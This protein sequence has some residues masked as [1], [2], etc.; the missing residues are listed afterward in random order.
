MSEFERKCVVVTGASSGIGWHAARLFALAGARVLAHYNRN[1]E[2]AESLAAEGNVAAVQADLPESAGI[3]PLRSAVASHLGGRVDVLVNNAGSLVQ[4][5]RFLELDEALWDTVFALNLKSA[6]LCS[7]AFLPGMLE[8]GDGA[9]INVS[10]IAG[11]NGGGLGAIAYASAK[12]G[13]ITFTKGLAREFSPRGI[14]VN[15]VAPGTIDTNYHKAFST[16]QMLDAVV[17]GT[18][19]G[20]LGRPEECAEVILFL[21]STRSSFITGETIEVNGGFL[22]D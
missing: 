17:A 14:R 12:G 4:R 7:R 20:R 6:Y 9:I 3:E 19:A 2:G 21:A 8:R 16:Q 11:R 15:C 13:M 10:S 1:R 5:R 18:P 22:M